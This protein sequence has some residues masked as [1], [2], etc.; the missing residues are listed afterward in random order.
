MATTKIKPGHR[1]VVI[2]DDEKL[3]GVYETLL[4]RSGCQ[5]TACADSSQ[6]IGLLKGSQYDVALLDISMP[7]LEGTD[8]L[9]LI[10]K[11]HPDMPV[12]LVSAYCD[13][14]NAAYYHSLGAFDIVGKPFSHEILLDTVGRALERQERIPLVLTSL[15]LREGRDQLYRKL[16]LAA[17]QKTDWNQVRAAELLGVSRYCL[18]RWLKKFGIS[19]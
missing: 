12:I 18:I 7:G 11:L 4:K 13:E 10:K 17:L 19:Y 8:L 6:V 9:P 15:S 3:L 1:A 5:V 14:T 16:I 2:D